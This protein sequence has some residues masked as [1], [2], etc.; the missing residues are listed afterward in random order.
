MK[1]SSN[2][3]RRDKQIQCQEFLPAFQTY[4]IQ[5]I[6]RRTPGQFGYMLGLQSF[7]H[8][9]EGIENR[10][11]LVARRDGRQLSGNEKGVGQHSRQLIISSIR[12][13]SNCLLGLK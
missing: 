11:K 6:V 1:N 5:T 9:G 4:P 12:A 13:G 8:M 2:N 10:V 3:K 7:N